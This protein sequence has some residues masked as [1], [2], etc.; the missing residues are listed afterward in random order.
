ML[1]FLRELDAAGRWAEFMPTDP[2]KRKDMEIK[3]LRFSWIGERKMEF[4]LAGSA[5]GGQPAF[6]YKRKLR[7][8]Y[9]FEQLTAKALEWLGDGYDP[10]VKVEI[11]NKTTKS[12]LTEL[13]VVLS[14]S[15]G[16]LYVISCKAKRG[17]VDEDSL[18]EAAR[19][20]RACAKTLNRFAVPLL[21]SLY[22]RGRRELAGVML[23]GPD[24]LCRPDELRR[25]LEE[26]EALLLTR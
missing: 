26:A 17:L 22:A 19:E 24:T 1:L 7:D 25:C 9:W 13:D 15:G 5:D 14:A 2:L 16:K 4:K 11:K 12:N 18:L 6:S 20:V 10:A 21:H 3:G 23:F 8:G